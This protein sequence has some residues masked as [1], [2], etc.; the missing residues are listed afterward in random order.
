MT[1]A[2]RGWVVREV[3]QIHRG[4]HD[5]C[6]LTRI[7]G[8]EIYHIFHPSLTSHT[9]LPSPPSYATQKMETSDKVSYVPPCLG[10]IWVLT[11]TVSSK[12]QPYR[13]EAIKIPVHAI[14]PLT[15][16]FSSADSKR[17]N[18]IRL[19]PLRMC[20]AWLINILA[21]GYHSVMGATGSGKSSVRTTRLWPVCELIRGV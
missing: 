7:R 20:R 16:H 2:Y 15:G 4:V 1:R 18:P 21:D 11:A 3:S 19:S 12:P 10:I 14:D 8:L 13:Y 6:E 9:S 5:L 17:N